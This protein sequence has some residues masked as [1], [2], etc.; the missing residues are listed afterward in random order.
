MWWLVGEF[1]NGLPGSPFFNNARIMNGM[2]ILL[3]EN[4]LGVIVDV[5]CSTSCFEANLK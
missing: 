5:H 2:V 1:N 4:V 3:S